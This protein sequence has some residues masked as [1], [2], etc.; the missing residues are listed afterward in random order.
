MY[1]LIKKEGINVKAYKIKIKA[2]SKQK[3]KINKIIGVSRFIYNFYI[4]HNK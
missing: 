2:T 1:K 3:T 4:S